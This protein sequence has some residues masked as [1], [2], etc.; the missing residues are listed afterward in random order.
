MDGGTEITSAAGRD[1]L[2]AAFPSVPSCTFYLRI[3][4]KK[5]V[6]RGR[7]AFK[8]YEVFPVYEEIS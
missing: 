3:A 2:T 6:R 7:L 4:Y 1:S 8:G 5:C